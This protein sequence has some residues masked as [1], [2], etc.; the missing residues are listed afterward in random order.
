MHDSHVLR[1]RNSII[2]VVHKPV[3]IEA[4]ICIAIIISIVRNPNS[5]PTLSISYTKVL[6]A[7]TKAKK[8]II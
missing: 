2:A 5:R 6:D 8:K 7:R 4:H 3:Y 1:L